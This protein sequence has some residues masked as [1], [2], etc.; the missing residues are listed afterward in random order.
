MATKNYVLCIVLSV[1]LVGCG[2]SCSE[3]G[4]KL[5]FSHFMN[6]W[7]GKSMIMVPQYRCVFAAGGQDE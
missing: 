4:G 3:R 6:I 5:A 2:P 1:F 7:N